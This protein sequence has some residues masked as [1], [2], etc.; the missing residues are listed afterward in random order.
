MSFK[1][2]HLELK[3]L[4]KRFFW[5]RVKSKVS[6]ACKAWAQKL[7]RSGRS[8]PANL[9]RLAFSN[10]ANYSNYSAAFLPSAWEVLKTDE[11][12]LVAIQCGPVLWDIQGDIRPTPETVAKLE[13]PNAVK[14]PL[15]RRL[16][17]SG[18]VKGAAML[19][20]V[21]KD[22]SWLCWYCIPLCLDFSCGGWPIFNSHNRQACLIIS[23][24]LALRK[25]ESQCA[26]DGKPRRDGRGGAWTLSGRDRL[27][28]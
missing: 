10:S 2:Q 5:A 14:G 21:S 3:V 8:D 24:T 26:D 20:G 28:R 7:T 22:P 17:P 9:Q 18:E 19:L 4:L 23:T 27:I 13:Q 16:H 1:L 6:T 12:V 11:Q 25:L 15:L